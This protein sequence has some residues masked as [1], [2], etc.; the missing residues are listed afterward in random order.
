[1]SDTTQV[2]QQT[3]SYVVQTIGSTGPGESPFNAL[4]TIHVMGVSVDTAVRVVETDTV[5]LW[6][7]SS[8]DAPVLP[9]VVI[10]LGQSPATPGR[11]LLVTGGGPTPS[12]YQFVEALPLLATLLPE[13]DGI[14]MVPRQ[15][16]LQFLNGDL[17]NTGVYPS[18][19]SIL[20]LHYQQMFFQP[21]GAGPVA[22][23]KRGRLMFVAA[24]ARSD[25]VPLDVTDNA[26]ND[27]TVVTVYKNFGGPEGPPGPPGPA[28][29][30]GPGG[31]HPTLTHL[32]YASSGHTGF[33]PLA[34]PV[35]TG[36]ISADNLSGTN[37]G[38]QTL[39]G[40][41]GVPTTRAVAGKALSAD[42]TLTASD[43]GADPAGAAAAITLAG[44]GGVP[45]TRT[46]NGHPLSVDVVV[47]VSDYFPDCVVLVA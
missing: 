13:Y 25:N 12:Y 44:L 7:P 29:P 19:K 3:L 2:T 14:T 34:S 46:V 18:G 43:V 30:P 27:T 26:T 20:T 17:S 11:W 42:V 39:S 47:S 9:A 10:P 31:D 35:F 21:L 32:D 4:E 38:D 40:L 37:T 24:G 16:T 28:G 15:N 1:M 36:D 6:H 41:G 5:Y 8:L 22:R 45:T 23:P 33:A